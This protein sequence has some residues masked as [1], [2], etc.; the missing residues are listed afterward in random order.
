M[1]PWH[2]TALQP[3]LVEHDRVP[4]YT[5]DI[6]RAFLYTW[7]AA[8]LSDLRP[9]PIL[10]IIGDKGG[11][12][13]TLAN[14]ILHVLMG[15]GRNVMPVSDSKRDF[16]A[17]VTNLPLVGF[18]NIDDDM[19]R[20]FQDQLA[21]VATGAMLAGRE[22]YTTRDLSSASATA[23]VMLTSRTA[24]FARPDIAD[25]ALPLI[26]MRFE[27]HVS[28][29]AI[30][31]KV[32]DCRDGLM[33]WCALTAQ[34]I[35]AGRHEAPQ[36]LKT[37][38]IDF[39]RMFWAYVNQL[40]QVSRPIDVP[41]ALRELDRARYHTVD[42]SSPLVDAIVR[43]ADNLLDVDGTWKGSASDLRRALAGFGASVSPKCDAPNLLE[44]V[45]PLELYGL[46]LEHKHYPS[47]NYYFTLCRWH[48]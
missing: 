35:R 8:I 19:P 12:K 26:T 14:A 38:A 20:W 33:S 23:A 32:D 18:D 2:S 10:G 5:A 42:K 43:H 47:G 44:I 15:P 9:L 13:S 22:L 7:M 29:D 37:R 16:A 17:A 40:G 30:M 45:Q 11:G 41:E 21:A 27:Q 46:R 48:D 36:E 6:Q 1:A 3:S 4:G 39:A 24:V 28:L 31:N 34:S 25:R